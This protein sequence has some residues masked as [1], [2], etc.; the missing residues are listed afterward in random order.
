MEAAKVSK[1]DVSTV[2]AVDLSQRPV[3]QGDAAREKAALLQLARRMHDAPGEM[4]PRFVELAMEL[5]GGISAGISLL[6]ETEPSPVFRWHHLKGILSPFNGATTPRDF[7]P[8]GITLERSAPTLTIH[9][10]RV[11]DW[12]PPGLSLPEVLLVPLYIGRTEPLGT[13]W[14][15]ADRIGHFHCGHGAT[16]QE[17]AGFI[18]IALKMVRSEQELQQALEQ[19]E[20]LTREMSHRLKNLFTIVDGMIRISARSTDN[21]DDLV[22]LLSGRLHALAAAHSLVR[23]SFSDVQGA[24]SNL[25]ELL[26]I[27]AEPHEPPTTGG[28]RRLSL[29]GPSVLCG[30]QSVNGLA[31]V[32]HEL[33]TN[34][35]K[36]GALCSE[37]GRV[38]VLWQIDGDDLSITWSE[39]RGT[40]ISIPPASKGFGSTL[41][42]ATVTHQFGGTLSYDWRPDGLSVNIV[43]P[44]SILA[45]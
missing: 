40:Q 13:L 4:L 14:I 30:E 27:V 8:C 16:M 34:A 44:L 23:P 9:P 18:G 22:A 42:E 28:R 15:V 33:A 20:L 29:R 3:P 36:Y 37:N 39:D 10:E 17:L 11:Y 32:F 26:S 31:L 38:D 45:R 25:A 21:K 43:M 24:A 5:T 12:I 6:E 35:A 1:P 7:S 19:Q 41:V 2:Y